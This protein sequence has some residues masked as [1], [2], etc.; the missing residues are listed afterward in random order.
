MFDLA[1][2]QAALREHKLDGWLLYDFRQINILA[3]RIAGTTEAHRSRRWAY[4]IPTT[5]EPKKLVHRIESSFEQAPDVGRHLQSLVM[6]YEQE[7]AEAEID[8]HT[9]YLMLV[10]VA[11][12]QK[13]LTNTL[14]ASKE[15]IPEA[16]AT[17]AE[18]ETELV[19]KLPAEL[20]GSLPTVEE[21]EAE[22]A[23]GEEER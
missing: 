22:L 10:E 6:R 21:I 9:L 17:V 4:F 2:I 14:R 19:A 5:G 1:S 11:F 16:L 23:N 8:K 3:A 18:W 12:N 7:L 13:V 15:T 20:R